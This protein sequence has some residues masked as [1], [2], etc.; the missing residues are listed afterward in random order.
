MKAGEVH[1]LAQFVGKGG[2]ASSYQATDGNEEIFAAVSLVQGEQALPTPQSLLPEICCGHHLYK[3][4]IRDLCSGTS[5]E[6]FPAILVVKQMRTR[7]K[8]R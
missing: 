2:F 5:R 6:N 3:H 4:P 7:N 1:L 8:V